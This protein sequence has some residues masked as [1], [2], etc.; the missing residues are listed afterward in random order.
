MNGY[1]RK[2]ALSSVP[3][4]ERAVLGDVWDRAAH[5]EDAPVF[6]QESINAAWQRISDFAQQNPGALKEHPAK[7]RSIVPGR[8]AP[9]RPPRRLVSTRK[10]WVAIAATLLLGAIGI[11]WWLTPVSINAPAGE[12]LAFTLPDGSNIHLNSGSSLLY[13]R[14]FGDTR[15]VHLKGEG[16]FDITTNGTPFVLKTFNARVEVLG[17]QFNV[18]A[19]ENSVAPA[20]SVTLTEGRV[21]F[22]NSLNLS[23]GVVM[24]PGETRRLNY[25]ANEISAADTVLHSSSLAWQQGDLVYRDELLGVILEDVER[26]FAIDIDLQA[27][28]L[29]EEQFTFIKRQPESVNEVINSLCEGL[30]LRYSRTTRGIVIY[31][32]APR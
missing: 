1:P 25:N 19:W 14:R 10:I 29:L 22:S 17:T 4:E 12:Q 18:K 16:F 30:G 3:A 2:E 31:P 7:N 26:K 6:S 23:E 27:E 8:A 9:S 15:E 24:A 11:N 32:P 5:A 13:P 20:T 21:L 28:D